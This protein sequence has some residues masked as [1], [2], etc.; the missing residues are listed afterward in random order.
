MVGA[1]PG[2][3]PVPAALGDTGA[4]A[5]DAAPAPAPEGRGSAD[6]DEAAGADGGAAGLDEPMGAGM[7]EEEGTGR[8]GV[9]G[10]AAFIFSLV[11]VVPL[12][13][14]S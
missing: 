7:V 2:G 11:V 12:R 8:P 14:K 5:V 6:D 3:I 4:R 13:E 10:A 1:P 9:P